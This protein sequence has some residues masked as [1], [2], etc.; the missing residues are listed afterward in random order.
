[1]W[2]QI[3]TEAMVA[4]RYI[5]ISAV[6]LPTLETIQ[7]DQCIRFWCPPAFTSIT[8]YTTH[9]LPLLSPPSL[10]SYLF[11]VDAT[12]PPT[13]RLMWWLLPMRCRRWG[14]QRQHVATANDAVPSQMCFWIEAT[15]P[16]FGRYQILN[17]CGIRCRCVNCLRFH[18]SGSRS[19]HWL[20]FYWNCRRFPCCHR[21]RLKGPSISAACFANKAAVAFASAAVAAFVVRSAIC[22]ELVSM[23]TTQ[24]TNYPWKFCPTWSKHHE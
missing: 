9:P 14:G 4:S 5:Y 16:T 20:R 15:S 23:K 7:Y 3:A 21:F 10:K 6:I 12:P 24:Y 17:L 1:M 13:M 22:H 18:R 8:F 19:F 11:C 2:Q